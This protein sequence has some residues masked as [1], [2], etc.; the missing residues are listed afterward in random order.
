MNDF[1]YKSMADVLKNKLINN[2]INDEEFKNLGD[3]GLNI[4]DLI[5]TKVSDKLNKD[6][7]FSNINKDKSTC[8]GDPSEQSIIKNYMKLNVKIQIQQ[9]N[10]KSNGTSAYDKYERYKVANDYNE[11][12]ELGG[13]NQDFYWDYRKG[14][15][16][17]LN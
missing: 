8:N 4:K 2:L 7:D 12:Y 5:V 6:I 14:Y 10:P 13:V 3:V 11:F 15:L 9:E 17:I 16:K 1:I